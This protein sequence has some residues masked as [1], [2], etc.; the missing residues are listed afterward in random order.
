[1]D[2]SKK[3]DAKSPS[4]AKTPKSSTSPA[5]VRTLA[6]KPYETNVLT[7]RTDDRPSSKT[8]S[9]N[10]S[11]YDD[12][13]K[14]S[15][16]VPSRNKTT[17]D[18]SAVTNNSNSGRDTKSDSRS[19][20]TPSGSDRK[21]SSP[22]SQRGAS[23]IVRSGLEVLHGHGAKDFAMSAGAFKPGAFGLN[24]LAAF[25]CP[26]GMEQ[27]AANPA[28]RP[29]FAGAPFSHHHAAMLA[30]AASAYPQNSQNP[31]FSYQR[32]KGPTGAETVVPICKDPYC[33]GCQ[34]SQH[35]QHMMLGIPCP[36]GCG[37][38]EQQ[39]Y[40]LAMAMSGLPANNPYSQLERPYVCSW[41]VGEGY[42]G[43]RCGTSDELVQHLR[44]HTSNLSDPAATAVLMQAQQR[45]LASMHP[46]SSLFSAS[47]LHRGYPAPLSP[48]SAASR[49]HPYAK[50]SPSAGAPA[51]PPTMPGSPYA[52]FNPA[53]L[54]PYAYSPY[55]SMYSQRLGAA[56][57][58]AAAHQ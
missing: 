38:C 27:H 15:A 34:F 13:P 43:K 14:S 36:A 39:K 25:A 7:T 57:A 2:K 45:A 11:V 12:K 58:A 37:Q 16:R 55:A 56:A 22:G 18:L 23:P 17:P 29:P 3:S 52:T 35:N 28:F 24:P 42:C 20:K 6:F 9:S 19:V 54:N 48:M 1:M 4:A 51:M 10:G 31:Y 40:G 50:P 49:Y 41:I 47:P 5:E 32:V 8:S 21:S 26:P 33:T 53:A 44:T 30:A 46:L